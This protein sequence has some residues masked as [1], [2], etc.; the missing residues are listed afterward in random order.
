MASAAREASLILRLVDQVTGPAKAIT[1]ALTNLSGVM[2]GV[3]TMRAVSNTVADAGRNMRRAA[4]DASALSLPMVVIG[5]EAAEAVYNFEKAGNAAEAYGNIT[6]EQRKELEAYAQVLNDESPFTLNQIM[7][8]ANE[9]F[10]AGL[11]FEQ[12]MGA[13]RGALQ[14]GTAGDLDVATATDLST[15][16][17]TSMRLPADTAE[18]VAASLEKV[19]DVLAFSAAQSN[20]DVLEMAEAFKYAG[21]VAT[22][23]GIPMNELATMFMVMAKNGIKGS[24]AGTALRSGIVRMLRPTLFAQRQLEALNIEMGDFVTLGEKIDF[25]NIQDAVSSLTGNDLA[26]VKGP[27]EALLEDDILKRSP[28][29]LVSR[30]MELVAKEVEASGADMEVIG[31]AVTQAIMTGAEKVDMMGFLK[32]LNDKGA[33]AVDM[34]YIWD[35][36]QGSR[37][38]SLMSEDLDKLLATFDGNVEG[39]AARMAA[40]RLKGIVGVVNEFDSAMSKL[41]I[42]VAESGVLQT[43]SSMIKSFTDWLNKMAELNPKILEFGTYAAAALAVL[44]PLGLVLSGLASVVAFIANPITL[45]VAALAYL[46]VQNWQGIVLFWQSLQTF[47]TQALSPEAV[48]MLG[49]VVGWFQQLPDAFSG[50]WIN[51]DLSTWGRQVGEGLAAVV[52]AVPK[53]LEFLDQLKT[54]A[55]PIIETLTPV[56]TAFGEGVMNIAGAIGNLTKGAVDGAVAFFQGMVSGISPETIDTLGRWGTAIAGFA[57]G[58]WDL[59][60]SIA[61]AV[62]NADMSGFTEFMRLFGEAFAIGLNTQVA[63]L[64]SVVTFLSNLPSL[65]QTGMSSGM[66]T[67]QAKVEEIKTWIITFFSSIDLAA[68]G[69]AIIDSLINGIVSAV[70]FLKETI[71][72]IGGLI[73]SIGGGGGGNGTAG[74]GGKM[75]GDAGGDPGLP[76]PIEG[77]RASGGPLWDG[78]FLAGEKGPELGY[79]SGNGHMFNADETKRMLTGAN[80][81][82][83]GGVTNHN[84]FHISTSDPE[85]AANAVARRLDASLQRSRG[86]SMEDRP[87]YG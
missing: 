87:V 46:A 71:D 16:I 74:G 43:V 63:L 7:D 3:R 10:K 86:L 51:A 64:D 52:N 42:S 26:N 55:Q 5:K 58:L 23:V 33:S 18:Q 35:V 72:G 59:I 11:N 8:A 6:A 48:A 9:L 15:N 56:F 27:I 61:G 45:I 83:G 50:Q 66:A 14:L 47:F 53:F 31:D 44:A 30:V 25:S 24:E 2:A 79:A 37:L 77:A 4:T 82:G 29:K 81:N 40:T 17:L 78:W 65:I 73:N 22:A 57:K 20:A 76:M 85:A 21:G 70:P 60:S 54:D 13:L 84:T 1:G 80:N 39:A 12:A 32:E 34:S 67:L 69:K 38:M 49:Q 41:Y 28:Q 19:N 62:A 68:I 75:F 36:R